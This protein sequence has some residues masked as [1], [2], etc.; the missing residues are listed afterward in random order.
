MYL[1]YTDEVNVDP[2]SSDFFVYAGISIPCDVAGIISAEMEKV[3]RLFGYRQE[4]ILKFNT[5]ERPSHISPTSHREIKKTIMEML[6]AYG[7]KLFAS[8]IS[9][10]VAK[11]PDQARRFEINRI[12][13]HFN[14]YLIRENDSGIVLIDTFNDSRLAGILREK[15]SIGLR[16]LPYSPTYR[17]ERILGFHLACIGSSHFSSIIDIVLGSLRY[18]INS[19][20]DPLKLC[21]CKSLIDQI[22]P[23]C[24]RNRLDGKV[25]E[26]SIF[27]SPKVIKSDRILEEYFALSK[28]FSDCGLEVIAIPMRG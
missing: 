13:F 27:F 24:I 9:H 23:M 11:D 18:A 20:L 7:V 4:D 25:D 10:D 16:G 6:P 21:V 3:R 5:V 28:Y 26:L 22:S 19:R 1:L 17:L 14:S 15:F 12:C 2:E 8:F